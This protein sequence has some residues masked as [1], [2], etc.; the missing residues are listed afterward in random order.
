MSLMG[1][2][3]IRDEL[4]NENP[5][6]ARFYAA[7]SRFAANNSEK[8]RCFVSYNWWV[9]ARAEPGLQYLVENL[10]HPT[11]CRPNHSHIFLYNFLLNLILILIVYTDLDPYSYQNPFNSHFSL[12]SLHCPTSFSSFFSSF[13]NRLCNV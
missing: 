6:G 4:L 9:A 1:I 13:N 2:S 8:K 3:N 7:F 5:P 12:L 10:H 11:S